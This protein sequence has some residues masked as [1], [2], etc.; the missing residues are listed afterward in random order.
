MTTISRIF[1]DNAINNPDKVALIVDN[2]ELTYQE[3]LGLVQQQV[4]ILQT[5]D[6]RRGDHLMIQLSGVDFVVMLLAA[7]DLGVALVPMNPNTPID[8]LEKAA[9]A[10]DTKI[11]IDHGFEYE[12]TT[13]NT[14]LKFAG[15]SEDLF[16]LITTSGSTGEPKPIALSQGTKVARIA[17]LIAT[18]DIDSNDV[19]LI[20]TPLYHSM[21]QRLILTSILTGGTLVIQ[22]KWSVQ[23]FRG[24]VMQHK[25][26]FAVPVASQVKQLVGFV[27]KVCNGLES[28]RCLVSS[29]E[30]LSGEMM[31]KVRQLL[32]CPVHNCYGTSEVAIATNKDSDD[33]G[34]VTSVGKPLSG[35][36]VKI[37]EG[38]II[39]KTPCLFDGY[40]GQAMASSLSVID[41]YFRTGDLGRIDENGYLHI[42]GRTKEVISVGGA[43][44]YPFDIEA[45]LMCHPDVEQCAAYAKQDERFGEVVGIAVVAKRELTLGELQSFCLDYLVDS[46]LPRAFVQLLALPKTD[47]G[48]VRRTKLAEIYGDK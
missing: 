1:F 25:V 35:V 29:S 20:S 47:S 19:T 7:A 11:V 37:L 15:K 8:A 34:P 23:E 31:K 32:L 36:D 30:T 27:A 41:G 10:T 22:P 13:Y 39:V 17:S 45:V 16:L 43:K 44:V 5:Q 9:V 28:L 26:T 14:R 40:Y 12:K 21:A 38:E 46:Q 18:Y 42:L 4:H 24:L 48:K 6:V 2:K 33:I 3:L